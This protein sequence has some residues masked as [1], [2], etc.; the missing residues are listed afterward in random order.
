MHITVQEQPTLLQLLTPNTPNPAAKLDS[1]THPKTS[2]RLVPFHISVEDHILDL[3]PVGLLTQTV[4]TAILTYASSRP[5]RKEWNIGFLG[6]IG[7]A[8][9]RVEELQCIAFHPDVIAA[10]REAMDKVV[11]DMVD[12]WRG[13][14][15]LGL[16]PSEPLFPLSLQVRQS[17][18]D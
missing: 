17:E 16:R 7:L 1:T 3:K 8:L 12:C 14:G 4:L 11:K 9:N 6:D 15:I 18:D 10:G 13:Q 5:E 2:E